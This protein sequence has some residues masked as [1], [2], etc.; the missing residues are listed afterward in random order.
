MGFTFRPSFRTDALT[1]ISS[2]P[3]PK[4]LLICASSSSTA[5]DDFGV[6]LRSGFLGRARPAVCQL[7]MGADVKW[8]DIADGIRQR[9]ESPI[10]NSFWD[11][12]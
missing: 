7:S 9:R 8:M 11:V 10:G 2:N 4:L 1:G 12:R 3:L 6:Q 5:D